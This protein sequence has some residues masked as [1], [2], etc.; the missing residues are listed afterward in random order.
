MMTMMQKSENG[1]DMATSR[2]RIDF[3]TEKTAGYVC[4]TK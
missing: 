2:F 1:I 3:R 4:A